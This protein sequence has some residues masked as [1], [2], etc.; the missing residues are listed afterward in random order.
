MKHNIILIGFMGSGKSTV[1]IRLS[2]LL[3]MPVVD[4]DKLIEKRAGKRISDI[5]AEDGEEAFR[6]QE[7]ECLYSLMAEKGR[8]IISTGGGL[9]LRRENRE[10]L[11][12]LG[13]VVYL[14][15]SPETIYERVKND[16][17]RPLLQ[18]EHPEKRIEELLSER[19]ALYASAADIVIEVDGKGFQEIIQEIRLRHYRLERSRKRGMKILVINGPNLNFLGIR[20][21]AV[22]GSSGWREKSC[23]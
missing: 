8:K 9:P 18:T 16:T 19:E 12:K 4:T 13:C 5:F 22:Y 2:Y 14:K 20:E 3:R 6:R 1:G 23:L 15:A 17:A 11:K 21:K 10:A 7:Q